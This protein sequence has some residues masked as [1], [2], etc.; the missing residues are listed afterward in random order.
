VLTQVILGGVDGH[1]INARTALAASNALPRSFEIPSIAHL[2]HELF[3][4]ARAFARWLRHQRFGVLGFGAQG[5]TPTLR[6]QL[7]A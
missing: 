6:R 1:S 2:L 5:F 7:L 4:Q 3:R